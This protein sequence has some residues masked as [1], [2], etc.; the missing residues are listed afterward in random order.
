MTA[1]EK[2]QF[3]ALRSLWQA[4]VDRHNR[5]WDYEW[6]FSLAVWTSFAA[7]AGALLSGSV[8]SGPSKSWLGEVAFSFLAVVV[9]SVVGG[10]VRGA[11]EKWVDGAVEANLLDRDVAAHYEDQLLKFPEMDL[12]SD[13]K[14]RIDE[15]RE[16]RR[17]KPPEDWSI[18]NEKQITRVLYW[19]VL[20]AAVLVFVARVLSS[21]G[22]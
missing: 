18:T 16:K 13:L 2:N 4:A 19:S 17:V 6:K 14:T 10:M 3:D 11:Y 9:I 22:S 5:R 12:L 8:F 15:A 1:D 7:F 20:A 21:L